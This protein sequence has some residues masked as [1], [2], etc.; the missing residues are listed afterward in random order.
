MPRKQHPSQSRL[1]QF[2]MIYRNRWQD[3]SFTDGLGWDEKAML[4]QLETFDGISAAG[5]VRADAE[6]LAQKHPDKDAHQIEGHLSALVQK[7]YIARSGSEVFIRSWFIHQPS[8]LRAENNVKQMTFAINRVGY[9]DL[10]ETVA[11]TFFEAL[12][13]IERVDKTQTAVKIKRLCQE[14]ADN[15]DIRLPR[16]L[17]TMREAS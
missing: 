17:A 5:V 7:S 9:D 12:L 8:Q 1:G 13:E 2:T 10:R 6:I 15:Q 14:L 16:A 3:R 4:M 11:Q